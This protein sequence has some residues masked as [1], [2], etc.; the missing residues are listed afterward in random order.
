MV[1]QTVGTKKTVDDDEK[2]L[3][4]VGEN[5]E[6][7]FKNDEGEGIFSGSSSAKPDFLSPSV[8]EIP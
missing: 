7:Q 1:R 2:R 4:M 8:V 3:K 5:V 6:K